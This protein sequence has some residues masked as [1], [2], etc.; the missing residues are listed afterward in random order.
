MKRILLLLFAFLGFRASGQDAT[1]IICKAEA[2]MQGESSQ[3]EMEMKVVRPSWERTITFK[4]WSKGTTFSMVL[5][6]SPARDKGQSFLKSRNDM[7][8]WNPTINRMIKMPPSMMSQGWMGSDYSNDDMMKESSLVTEF[9]HKI[10]RKEQVDNM[11]C[12]VIELIPT[13]ESSVV[14]GKLVM[15]ISTKDYFEM[16][17][18]FYDEDMELVKT[19][20]AADIRF[21][22]DRN[23]PTRFEIIPA[24]KPTQK[25]I[26][27]IKNIRFNL[28]LNESFFTQQNMKTLK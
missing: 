27:Q 9:T 7:W 22:H 10:L 8:S 13:D 15:W 1:E 3:S 24:D 28:P 20:L 14:W 2:K 23:I 11:E 6:L 16:K 18:E 12:W 5:I 25:T 4:T 17:S 26:V 21:M 19:H